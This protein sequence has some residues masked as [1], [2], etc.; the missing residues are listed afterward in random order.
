MSHT[1]IDVQNV[2]VSVSV[3]DSLDA[4][5]TKERWES[6]V[7]RSP[8]NRVDYLRELSV[9][10]ALLDRGVGA[11]EG[12]KLVHG[13]YVYR[14]LWLLTKEGTEKIVDPLYPTGDDGEPRKPE[15]LGTLVRRHLA[16]R[17]PLHDGTV[18]VTE[19]ASGTATRYGR[20]ARLVFDAGFSPSDPDWRRLTSELVDDPNF[21]PLF[22][23]GE[24]VT[25]KSVLARMALVDQIA[26]QSREAAEEAAREAEET[27]AREAEEAANRTV[28]V[29]EESDQGADQGSDQDQGS[30]DQGSDQGPDT[31]RQ[32]TGPDSDTDA[33]TGSTDAGST[34]EAQMPVAPE[35]VGNG[36]RIDQ[37]VILLR[38]CTPP[39][40]D[41]CAA[42]H[43]VR[44]EVTRLLS[45]ATPANR[46]A[47]KLIAEVAHRRSN[48][49]ID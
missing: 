2:G 4:Q 29:A 35:P 32:G 8:E 13:A 49:Q 21:Y 16:T 44:A 15:P 40:A 42:L 30:T 20:V 6:A 43:G 38:A 34:R 14:T 46:A 27:A 19:L 28:E 22:K 11:I 23:K 36:A 39:D 31:T 9:G 24:A 41:D 1:D 18:K 10:F 48:G 12:R 37:I 47:G 17:Q 7:L 3:D 25:R 33:A 45:S 5:V 26:I